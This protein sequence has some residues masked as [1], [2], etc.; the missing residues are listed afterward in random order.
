MNEPES[1][2]LLDELSRSRIFADYQKAFGEATGLPLA[3]RPVEAWQPVH[4]GNP[5]ENPFCTLMAKTSRTCAACLEVQERI[6]ENPGPGPRT[7]TC[8]AGL[9]DTAIPLRFGHELVGFL[10]TGQAFVGV[11]GD[12][13]R[14]NKVAQQ[15]I[16]W[17]MKTDL[18]KVEEAWFHSRVLTNSQY[19]AM[20][21]L[22]SIFAQ[23]LSIVGNQLLVQERTAEPPAITRARK[24]IDEHQAETLSLGQVA[25]AV[26]MSSFYFCKVFKK[27]TGLNF[28]DYVS[29]VRIERAKNLLLNPNV[30]ITEVAYEVGF[31]TLTHFNRVFRKVTGESPSSY[32]SRL[33]AAKVP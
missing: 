6:A 2:Q 7:V 9:T 8:F 14:F 33:P 28:T 22:L 13:T 16:Q 32:R 25:Q 12:K 11:A 3:L 4:Q 27:A 1:R 19:Q 21:R 31:Q 30:R 26:N 23:H 17:G 18:A 20:V 15:L 10:Q 24:F 5:H 29:R